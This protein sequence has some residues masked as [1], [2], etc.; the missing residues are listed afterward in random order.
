MARNPDEQ[1]HAPRRR[2]RTHALRTGRGW[3]RNGNPAGDPS[4]AP[5]SGARTRG[6]TPCQ[7]PC[8][9]GRPR[10]RMHGGALGSGAPRGNRNAQTH[11]ERTAARTVQRQA[12]RALLAWVRRERP[13]PPGADADALRAVAWRRR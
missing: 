10:C 2:R 8:V 11:G 1:P 3:L 12:A 5:R 4:S 7:A 6:G 13:L 9:R